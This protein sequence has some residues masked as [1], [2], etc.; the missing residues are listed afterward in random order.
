MSAVP[1]KFYWNKICP[2]VH[3][4]WIAAIEKGVPYLEYCHVP[5]GDDMPAWYKEVNP[6][7]TVPALKVGDKFVYESLFIAQYF[8]ENFPPYNSLMPGT[9]KQRADIRFFIDEFKNNVLGDLYGLIRAPDNELDAKRTALADKLK[10]LD[11]AFNKLNTGGPYFLGPTFSLA[12]IVVLPF[13]DR[14]RHLHHTFAS[15]D[16]LSHTPHLKRMLAAAETRPSMTQTMQSRDFYLQ[17]Y[18]KAG[19]S[20]RAATATLPKPKL[21]FSAQCPYVH[22]AWIA[23]N[24]KEV[25]Y[26]LVE[27]SLESIPEWYA[28]I[29]PRETLPTLEISKGE[30]VFESLFIVEYISEAYEA[31]GAQSLLLTSPLDKAAARFF[32]D[33]FGAFNE[34]MYGVMRAKG[35][36]VAKWQAGIRATVAELELQ[37]ASQSAGPFFAGKHISF[38]DIAVIPFLVR[39]EVVLPAVLN[40]FNPISKTDAPRL[41]ALLEAAKKLEAVAST[42][43]PAQFYIDLY[44]RA[45]AAHA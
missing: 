45:V 10:H 21:Y 29:N 40:G 17:A 36:D 33:S 35:D 13:L 43:K 7:E 30:Y 14:F 16:L 37:L 26:E 19:Y 25:S 24:L 23:L 11:A 27:V 6:R 22:R 20:P 12:D 15:F 5:L 9:P 2:F 38:A 8:D 34:A 44:K 31:S 28:K 18:T 39:A 32:V 1:L 4:S 3:T 42:L 41:N